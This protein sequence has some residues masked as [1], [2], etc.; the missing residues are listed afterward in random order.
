MPNRTKGVGYDGT[1]PIREKIDNIDKIKELANNIQ[2]KKGP[3][4]SIDDYDY[5]WCTDRINYMKNRTYKLTKDD[6]IFANELWKI[7]G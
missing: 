3:N 7:Y 5:R 4:M 6:M 1:P 2:I